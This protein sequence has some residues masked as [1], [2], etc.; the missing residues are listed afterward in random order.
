MTIFKPVL[1]FIVLSHLTSCGPEVESDTKTI[2]FHTF[3]NI[4][5]TNNSG[6]YPTNVMEISN[7]IEGIVVNEKPRNYI[8]QTIIFNDLLNEGKATLDLKALS[9]NT[10]DL[11][12]CN[13]VKDQLEAIFSEEKIDNSLLQKPSK[14]ETQLG[15]Y[16]DQHYGKPNFFIFHPSESSPNGKYSYYTNIEDLRMKISALFKEN[17]SIKTI[18]IAYNPPLEMID[19][20]DQVESID[21]PKEDQD[22]RKKNIIPPSPPK[23]PVKPDAIKISCKQEDE[24]TTFTWTGS[25]AAFDVS[26]LDE[27]SGDL[28]FHDKRVRTNELN[29]SEI[30]NMELQHNYKLVVSYRGLKK[31]T[32][33]RNFSLGEYNHRI[34]IE[35][36][37]CK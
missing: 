22:K 16:L 26:I 28:V 20:A 34:I 5:S 32:D 17:D 8:F 4:A 11:N 18:I 37:C 3:N 23:P 35:P 6:L 24:R 29:V 33:N 15:T 14:Q 1:A 21:P 36:T 7:P 13:G 27:E 12:N 9:N 25:D 30:P 31:Y 2:I 10:V 19:I